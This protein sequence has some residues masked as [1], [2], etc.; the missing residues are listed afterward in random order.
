MFPS[1]TRS[2]RTLGF[3]ILLCL[4]FTLAGCP[5]LDDQDGGEEPAQDKA[6]RPADDP[7]EDSEEET[8]D[9]READREDSEDDDSATASSQVCGRDVVAS[10]AKLPAA[11]C[12]RGDSVFTSTFERDAG[13]PDE[14]TETLR[15]A[16]ESRVCVS[17]DSGADGGDRVSAAWVYVDGDLLFGPDRFSQQVDHARENL[18]LPAGEHDIRVRLASKPGATLGVEVKASPM[19]PQGDEQPTVVGEN[20]ILEVTNV[21]VDHPMFSPNGDG[22]HET[23]LFNADNYPTELPGDD[24]GDYEYALEWSWSIVDADDCNEDHVLSG[25]TQVNSP[26]NVQTH[27]DGRDSS[28]DLLED[29]RYLYEYHVDLVRSDGQI[30]DSASA[31]ARGI[32][33]D[34]TTPDFGTLEFG[35]TC[36]PETDPANCKCP[37][38][39]PAGTRCTFGW[40][41]YVDS[42]EDPAGVDTEQFLT[43]RRDSESGRWEV[44]V[45]L[46]N[47]NGGGLVPQHDAEYASIQALQQYVSEL[48]GVPADDDRRQLFNFDYVQL[49]YST[50]VVRKEGIADGFNHFLLDVI[51]DRNGRL[52]I[53]GRTVDLKAQLASAETPVPD[54]LRIREAR[55]G[56]DCAENGNT[57]GDSTIRAKS[58]TRVRTANLDPGG[59]DL[60]VYVLKSRTF[61]VSIDG[62]GTVRDE[63]CIINGIFKCGVRTFHRDADLTAAATEYAETGEVRAVRE[64]ETIGTDT[65]A[66]VVH[67]NRFAPGGDAQGGSPI[68]GACSRNLAS[69]GP[70]ATPLDSAAGAVS[71]SCIINGIF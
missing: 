5:F 10:P 49:G 47:Y 26:T 32:L 62:Q 8:D 2:R 51:T 39:L 35:G 53:D 68:D 13:P 70:M 71:P 23:A 58:C 66:M 19:L 38:D 52:T 44:V 59:T 34:T 18:V 36:D 65:P 31:K 57:D 22:Y 63:N 40:I 25:T 30:L 4:S 14:S 43:S 21:A 55:Q 50:P 61:D 27:W 54:A 48:T 17:L 20:D 1:T 28:G 11:P 33:I 67:T 45:D 29:G 42:F 64:Y 69:I 60:G 56:E 37:D 15:L 16:T 41:P 12:Q 24:E 3:T 9:D 46:R 6:D 7:E